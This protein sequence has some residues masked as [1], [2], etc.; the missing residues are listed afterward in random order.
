LDRLDG[1]RQLV[2]EIGVAALEDGSLDAA[3]ML[4]QFRDRLRATDG[5]LEELA[6][7]IETHRRD[8]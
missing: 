2:V 3:T 8:P 4:V 6:G 5:D 1:S 7:E